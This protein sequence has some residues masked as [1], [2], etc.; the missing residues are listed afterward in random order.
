MNRY[1]SEAMKFSPTGYINKGL[2]RS[3]VW[4][5]T[6]LNFTYISML[7]FNW[8]SP[9]TACV[10]CTKPITYCTEC[11]IPVV[12]PIKTRICMS[13]DVTFGEWCCFIQGEITTDRWYWT[14]EIPHCITLWHIPFKLTSSANNRFPPS[15]EW[16]S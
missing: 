16:M 10:K 1:R 12:L 14:R 2:K 11:T 13:K 8:I 5:K 7:A 9:V 15:L 3:K 4:A 6:L